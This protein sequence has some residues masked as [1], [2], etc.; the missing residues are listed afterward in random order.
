LWTRLTLALA[1]ALGLSSVGAAVSY[2]NPV[3][4]Q[5]VEG[6][7]VFSVVEVAR[8][9]ERTQADEFA[10]A[11]AVLVQETT[12]R[13]ALANRFAGVLWF[14]DQYLTESS[15]SY[16]TQRPERRT[17]CTGAVLAVNAGD[18]D[19]RAGGT[20]AFHAGTY[21]ESYRVTDPNDRLWHVDKWNLS[22]RPAWTVAI[23]D[24]EAGYSVPDNGSCRGATVSE[25]E[26]GDAVLQ[27][28]FCSPAS[29]VTRFGPD[30]MP[31]RYAEDPGDHGLA[32][33]PR[34]YNALLYFLLEDLGVDAAPKD[35]RTGSTDWS[36]D[37]AGCH[38]PVPGSDRT[39]PCPGNDD[40]REGNS[41]PYNPGGTWF[42]RQWAGIDN[43]G[44][45]ADCTGDGVPDADCHATRLIDVYFGVA[46]A[47]PARVFPRVD[48]LVGSSAPYHCHDTMTCV[49][50][51]PLS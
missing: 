18:A 50:P 46:A 34:V 23:M 7:T 4:E 13:P 40:D 33:R 15:S 38:P 22:G 44:G 16:R 42:T 1:L 51:A 29:F 6:H 19:P 24:N 37:G 30:G 26:C 11:V 10:A 12:H 32:Y 20:A 35:H 39:F 47:P 5:L 3:V 8:A 21:V 49:P 14:N 25:R 45:S 48:D 41:H 31:G 27:P 2:A 28:R 36:Q 9:K 43:H 17:P